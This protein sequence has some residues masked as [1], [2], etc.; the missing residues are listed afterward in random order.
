MTRKAKTR[1]YT[2]P[3]LDKHISSR[4]RAAVAAFVLLPLA[5]CEGGAYPAGHYEGS[6]LERRDDATI[7][8]TP[9]SI[10]LPPL[11]GESGS[12]VA[13][14][15]SGAPVFE[16]SASKIRRDSF[17]LALPARLGGTIELKRDGGCFSSTGSLE[18]HLCAGAGKILLEVADGQGR[19]LLTLSGD[20]F[21]KEAPFVM[22][23]PKAFTLSEIVGTAL[24]KNFDSRIA[25]E[26][27]IEAKKGAQ[28]AYLNL[29]PHLSLSTVLNNLSPSVA[30]LV[31]AIGDLAPF[32]LPNRWFQAGAAAHVAQAQADALTLMRADLGTEV[33]G[34]VYALINDEENLALYAPLLEKA[35]GALALVSAFEKSSQMPVGSTIH[36]QA[37]IDWMK[38]DVTSLG[39]L[40][41]Q[42][43]EALAA[44][45]GFHNPEAV[46]EVTLGAEATPI[47]MA[48]RQYADRL[49]PVAL[50]RSFELQQ[51]D[52]LVQAA[53][54]QKKELLFSWLDPSGD[55]TTE[56]G[57]SLGANVAVAQAQVSEL[58][59]Q[60]EKLQ[61][62]IAE[63]VSGATGLWNAAL[64]SYPLMQQTVQVQSD[65]MAFVLSEIGPGSQLNT[66]DIEAVIQ[67]SLATGIRRAGLVAQ[68][69]VARS[70]VDR[71]L[72]QGA[73]LEFGQLA[74]PAK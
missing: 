16:V 27:L 46:T 32:L 24:Q 44:A 11:K 68:F 39:L 20:K 51:I 26:Q 58:L 13:K 21:A 12:V 73:Y 50:A 40:V 28:A 1:D 53:Y 57:I 71:L 7:S 14:D 49:T 6:L 8:S 41:Q 33:E 35:N 66:M 10:D 18:I 3:S 19:P 9:V 54:D 37:I 67:D 2:M 4:M 15:G 70:R 36:V 62:V 47:D 5:A 30:S 69:R 43:K 56:L 61:A 22:E 34:L 74:P 29:L 42:D 64:D 45:M 38:L 72:L 25:Y 52:H 48:P 59:T 17:M 63:K 23:A 60:R 65:R 31:G 55:P